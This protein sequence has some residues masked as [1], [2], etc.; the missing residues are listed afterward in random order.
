MPDK[1]THPLQTIEHNHK[2]FTA[3]P[4][5]VRGLKA[6]DHRKLGTA[7]K[8]LKEKTANLVNYYVYFRDMKARKLTKGSLSDEAEKELVTRG[9]AMLDD[10]RD[11]SSRIGMI[12]QAVTDSGLD[13]AMNRHMDSLCKHLNH[14][15]KVLRVLGELKD[16]GITE[17]EISCV[18]EELRK[19]NYNLLKYGG[20]DGTFDGFVRL[21]E[22]MN[23]PLK[24]EQELMERHGLP[25]VQGAG[26]ST[27]GTTVA[28]VVVIVVVAAVLCVITVFYA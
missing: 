28:V 6:I 17:D 3:D 7:T 27:T 9:R 8:G 10:Y 2:R 12:G 18:W 19:N 20:A 23:E 24:A 21:A 13:K 4:D 1:T 25:T 14:N 5:Y 26:G 15:P 11:I 22:S 16:M